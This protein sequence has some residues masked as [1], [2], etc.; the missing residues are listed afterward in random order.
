[1]IAME[2]RPPTYSPE[3]PGETVTLPMPKTN[4]GRFRA[5]ND[6][7]LAAFLYE[8]RY[9]TGFQLFQELSG[10]QLSRPSDWA[11]WLSA[12]PD[13]TGGEVTLCEWRCD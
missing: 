5:M 1:M 10:V 9:L 4:G 13:E 7:E 2:P 8:R 11:D 3:I 6:A 12:K